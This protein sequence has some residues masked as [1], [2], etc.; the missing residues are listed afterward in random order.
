[1]AKR[2][3]GAVYYSPKISL[4][5]PPEISDWYIRQLAIDTCAGIVYPGI[6]PP[7][8]LL[9]GCRDSF[10]IALMSHVRLHMDGMST[11]LEDLLP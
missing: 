9:C 11:M 7:E 5:K 1:M 8:F 10:Y 4:K 3:Q 6:E 2:R